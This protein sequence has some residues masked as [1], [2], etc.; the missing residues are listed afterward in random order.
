MNLFVKGL[1]LFLVAV[2]LVFSL[3]S[4]DRG[5]IAFLRFFIIYSAIIPVSLKVAMEFGKLLVS[6]GIARD[7]VM[8][9]I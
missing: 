2:S 5:F 9:R 3:C 7:K 8:T 1:F 4:A 6:F